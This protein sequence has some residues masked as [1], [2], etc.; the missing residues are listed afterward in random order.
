LLYDSGRG[1]RGDEVEMLLNNIHKTVCYA[2][3]W[4]D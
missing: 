3:F 1:G 2:L 4:T